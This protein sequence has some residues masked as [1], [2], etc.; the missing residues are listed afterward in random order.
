[1]R[2]VDDHLVSTSRSSWSAFMFNSSSASENPCRLKDEERIWVAIQ[3]ALV[4][5]GDNIYITYALDK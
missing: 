5:E 2:Y 4:T 3:L 1:M